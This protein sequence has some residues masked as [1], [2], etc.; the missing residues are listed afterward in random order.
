MYELI[1]Y[2]ASVLVALSLMMRSI[3][4]LRIIN[5][6][7]AACFVVYGTLINAYPV[8][9]VNFIIVLINVYYLYE[10]FTAREYFNRLEVREDSDYLRY[11]LDFHTEQIRRFLP[12]F[13]FRPGGNRVIFFVLRN[14]IP[15]GI[16]IGTRTAPDTLHVALDF[17]I[18]GYRDMKIGAYLYHRSRNF[19]L[20]KG[21]RTLESDPGNRAHQKYLRRMGFSPVTTPEG[22]TRFQLDLT[23]PASH[24]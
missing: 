19:F 10:L 8:A 9:L 16:F 15:A 11:F 7:G 14:L 21:I 22:H 6:V 24:R 5:L 18:P 3:L 13:T 2:V 4:R 20:E 17:V 1:G 12:G 23:Q